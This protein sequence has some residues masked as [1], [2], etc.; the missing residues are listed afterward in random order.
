MQQ[1]HTLERDLF[2]E[3]YCTV[4]SIRLYT[5]LLFSDDSYKRQQTFFIWSGTSHAR[6]T[7]S[8]KVL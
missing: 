2:S 3:H 6:K 1:K 7:L 5:K 8:N 4:T